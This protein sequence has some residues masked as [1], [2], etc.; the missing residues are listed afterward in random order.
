MTLKSHIFQYEKCT[1]RLGVSLKN[2]TLQWWTVI[3]F[4]ISSSAL[5]EVNHQ[6]A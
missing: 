2:Q 4:N 1:L 6:S 5:V 3:L